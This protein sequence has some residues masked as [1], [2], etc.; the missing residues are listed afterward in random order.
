MITKLRYRIL[1][2]YGPGRQS[3]F[4]RKTGIRPATVSEYCN[5]RRPIARRHYDILCRLLDCTP[6]DI[7]GFVEMP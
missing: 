6:S 1:Q 5:G 3:E 2:V 7:E 4:A